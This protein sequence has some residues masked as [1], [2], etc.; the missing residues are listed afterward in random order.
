[1]VKFNSSYSKDLKRDFGYKSTGGVTIAHALVDQYHNWTKFP[2]NPAEVQFM[3]K[4]LVESKTSDQESTETVKMP[5]PDYRTLWDGKAQELQDVSCGR[6][7]TRTTNSQKTASTNNDSRTEED[8]DYVTL[9]K[10]IAMNFKACRNAYVIRV[11]KTVKRYL[12]TE[13]F[14]MTKFPLQDRKKALHD[15]TTNGLDRSSDTFK[16]VKPLFHC[17][18]LSRE[19]K[20]MFEFGQGDNMG[21]YV[22]DKELQEVNGKLLRN[23]YLASEVAMLILVIENFMGKVNDVSFVV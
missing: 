8:D 16:V 6:F 20:A 2:L 19:K 12:N 14:G 7:F 23:E 18:A 3:K 22:K 11:T 5:S 13:R 10:F 9:Q 4:L 1:M 17:M 15:L 21:K